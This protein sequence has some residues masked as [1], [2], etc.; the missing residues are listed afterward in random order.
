MGTS[1]QM[2]RVKFKPHGYSQR[3]VLEKMIGVIHINI[4]IQCDLF[5]RKIDLILKFVLHKSTFPFKDIFI[6]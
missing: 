4:C 6:T 2:K 3:T 5:N 1:L